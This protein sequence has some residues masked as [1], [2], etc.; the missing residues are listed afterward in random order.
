M[1]NSYPNNCKEC[2][3][4]IM[5]MCFLWRQ[6]SVLGCNKHPNCPAEKEMDKNKHY[7]K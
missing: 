3:K 7:R 6:V 4:R 1:S 5:G 2:Y